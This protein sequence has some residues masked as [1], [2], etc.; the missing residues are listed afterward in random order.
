M[1]LE[2]K[3]LNQDF[4]LVMEDGTWKHFEFQSTNEGL[5]GLKRFRTYESASSYQYHVSIT[6]YVLYS[7]T[8]KNPMTEFSE[9][10]SKGCIIVMQWKLHKIQQVKSCILHKMN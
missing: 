9:E 3:K 1:Y 10:K 4:N 8:I 6:T 5:E 7:G 2:L